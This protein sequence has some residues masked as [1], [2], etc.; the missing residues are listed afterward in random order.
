M[1]CYFDNAATTMP[2]RQVADYLYEAMLNNY[3]NPSSLHKKALEAKKYI[4]YAT[5][6]IL[7]VLNLT[8]RKVIYTSG[9]TESANL[10]IK[11][12]R[13]I[14]KLVSNAPDSCP[15]LKAKVLYI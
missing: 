7:Q 2:H 14:L 13:M 8:G 1:E 9:A 12:C 4:D 6:Q 11:S 10:A 3:A 5:P 15:A